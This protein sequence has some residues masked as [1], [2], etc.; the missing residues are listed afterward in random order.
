MVFFV[1]TSSLQDWKLRQYVSPKFWYAA[2]GL[3]RSE[4][5][6]TIFISDNVSL[7][8]IW[9]REKLPLLAV[10]FAYVTNGFFWVRRTVEFDPWVYLKK[11]CFSVQ[12]AFLNVAHVTQTAS[13]NLFGWRISFKIQPKFGEV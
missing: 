10:D 12:K 4:N 9:I 6:K 7:F 11:C 5:Q 1:F 8:D 2:D 3:H 13:S